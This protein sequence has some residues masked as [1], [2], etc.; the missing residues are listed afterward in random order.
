MKGAWRPF[1]NGPRN[2]IAQGLV[3]TE[4][5]VFLACTIREFDVA[6]AYNEWDAVNKRS[7]LLEYRGDRAYQ[8]EEA[9]AHPATHYPCRVNV[10]NRL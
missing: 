2:C 4:L 7:G 5:C 3:M 6:D 10:R 1:E 9:A 8:I